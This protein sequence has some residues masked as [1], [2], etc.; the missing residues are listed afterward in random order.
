[1]SVGA[2]YVDI[3]DVNLCET[4]YAGNPVVITQPTK[5]V[6]D[7]S[8]IGACGSSPAQGSIII[9][10]VTGGTPGYQYSIDDGT[11][12]YPSS[13]TSATTYTFDVTPSTYN[14]AVRDSYACV[15]TY[16]FNPITI[17]MMTASITSFSPVTCYSGSNG[18]ITVSATGG[19][20]PYVYSISS[21]PTSSSSFGPASADITGLAAGTYVVRVTDAL[22]QCFIDNTVTI[23]PTFAG[24][25]R[26]CLHI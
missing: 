14:I 12:W 9:S 11:T 26:C 1:M 25:G 20:M 19:I 21:T 6:F 7:V 22:G 3:K 5:I 24:D 23:T 15:V 8:Q 13:T 2:Y 17:G 16:P 4:T 18:T 10:D